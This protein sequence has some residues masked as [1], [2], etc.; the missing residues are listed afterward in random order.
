MAFSIRTG[1]VRQPMNV[2]DLESLLLAEGCTKESYAIG[3]R[4]TASDAFCLLLN[5]R[6]WE[7]F[8]TE[9]GVDSQPIFSSKSESEACDFFHKH[10][11]SLPHWHPVGW[12]TSEADAIELE[13]RIRSL[14]IQPIRNDIPSYRWAGDKRYRIFVMGKDIF[15]VRKAIPEAPIRKEL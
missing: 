15:P 10:I 2:S 13:N 9:R 14:G 8:Y 1:L 6:M 11:L 12:F 4:G 3:S 7:V 5:D